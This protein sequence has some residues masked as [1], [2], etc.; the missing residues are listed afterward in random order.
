MFIHV[1]KYTPGKEE[2][3]DSFTT[4]EEAYAF[5]DSLQAAAFTRGELMSTE[6]YGIRI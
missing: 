5:R 4:H 1:I 6:R 3:L 2:D